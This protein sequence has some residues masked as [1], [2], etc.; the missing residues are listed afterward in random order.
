[1]I[2][3]Y[4]KCCCL[5]RFRLFHSGNLG[6]RPLRRPPHPRPACPGAKCFGP[7]RRAWPDV[8]GARAENARGNSVRPDR[9]A[10][11]DHPSLSPMSRNNERRAATS[12]A[13]ST[14]TG[15]CPSSTPTTPRRCEA[16]A[17]CTRTGLALACCR[18]SGC[19]GGAIPGTCR[20]RAA[21]AVVVAGGL[22]RVWLPL[23]SLVVIR[24][25]VVLPIQLTFGTRRP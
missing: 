15:G 22:V 9:A 5:R 4:G 3:S 11:T 18:Q 14:P 24:Y 21:A 17:T 16:T 20:V 10:R 7:S 19:C 23:R 12:S 13:V 2:L 6:S 8:I 1:M 25:T